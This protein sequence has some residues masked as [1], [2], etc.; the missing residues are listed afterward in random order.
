[1]AP[2]YADEA[3]VELCGAGAGARAGACVRACC[4]TEDYGDA[5]GRNDSGL[6]SGFPLALPLTRVR[7]F[8]GPCL[9]RLL[10]ERLSASLL[11]S[12]DAS[13]RSPAVRG[14]AVGSRAHADPARTPPP[15]AWR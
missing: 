4:C 3:E 14:P 12:D 5:G 6:I 11:A 2:G 9:S 7:S 13:N 10:F 1:M 8:C 15:A